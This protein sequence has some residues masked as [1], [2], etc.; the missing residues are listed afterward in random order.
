MWQSGCFLDSMG[1]KK[2]NKAQGTQNACI[3]FFTAAKMQDVDNEFMRVCENIVVKP[4]MFADIFFV[5]YRYT[6]TELATL[7]TA[8]AR[9]TENRHA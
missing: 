6:N 5:T 7:A 3:Y 2:V 4:G 9:R 8:H 1:E